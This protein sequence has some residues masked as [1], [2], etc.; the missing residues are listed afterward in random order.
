MDIVC[1]GH[2]HIGF[3][4]M[5]NL[6]YCYFTMFNLY[7]CYFTMFKFLLLLFSHCMYIMN[8]RVFI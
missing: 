5:F 8:S 2:S 4:T 1:R 3:L 7:Y 6:Y